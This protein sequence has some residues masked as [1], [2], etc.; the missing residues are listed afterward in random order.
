ME[1][2]IYMQLALDLAQKGAGHVSPNP[3]VGAVL[4]REGK[5]IGRGFHEKYGS[6]HAE[7][8]ALLDARVRGEKIEGAT[9][10]CNLEPCSHT[11]KQTPP[12]APL[13]AEEKIA[14]VVIANVDQ[15]PQ[16]SGSGIELLRSHGIEVITGVLEE[17]GRVLNESFF[18]FITKKS[19]FV[20]LKLAQTLDGRI[21]TKTGDSKYITGP[22]A[23]AYVHR[24]RQHYDCIMVGRK[25]VE[26]DNPSLTTRSEEF[27][28]LSHPLRLVLGAMK[29]LKQDWKIFSDELKRNTMMVATE[30]D[31]R[32]H[33]DVAFFLEQKG[34]ALLSSAA[35]QNGRVDLPSVLQ[36]LASLKMTSILLEGGPTLATE[37]LKQGLV[38][39][40]SFIIAPT[41]MGEGI[42]SLNDLGIKLLKEKMDLKNVQVSQLGNDILVEG[43]LCSQD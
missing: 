1:H 17:K 4:V 6:A 31:I 34:I 8:N 37:F 3:M 24:L 25:T 21:A 11:K 36:S 19:P 22:E 10:Y 29:E 16:V 33:Q 13:I 40:I 39:K 27:E 43:Y 30:A 2:E 41:L 20:H 12:C 15:N 42:N 23:S 38:D 5:I 9:L 7:V 35:D 26:A 18:K 28:K 14:R 32:A